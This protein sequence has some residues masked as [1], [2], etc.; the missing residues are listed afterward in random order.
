MQLPKT[1]LPGSAEAFLRKEESGSFLMHV[2]QY[3]SAIPNVGQEV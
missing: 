2:E 1:L 3:L